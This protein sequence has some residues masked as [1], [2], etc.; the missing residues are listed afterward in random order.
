MR[1]KLRRHKPFK[2][3]TGISYIDRTGIS[4]FVVYYMNGK[5][6]FC[7]RDSEEMENFISNV[8]FFFHTFDDETGEILH[9]YYMNDYEDCV[10]KWNIINS[11]G[12]SCSE[13]HERGKLITVTRKG[14]MIQTVLV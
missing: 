7:Y 13:I 11:A 5:V 9:T 1:I 3:E 14:R 4:T 6:K 2:N 10:F 8:S 12:I